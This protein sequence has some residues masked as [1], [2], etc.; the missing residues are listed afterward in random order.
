MFFLTTRTG[1]E[2]TEN[3]KKAKGTGASSS[4]NGRWVGSNWVQKWEAEKRALGEY[5]PGER[6]IVLKKK[7]HGREVALP[8]SRDRHKRRGLGVKRV[9]IAQRTGTCSMLFAL[10]P[11][12]KKKGARTD[13]WCR[14]ICSK[15]AERETDRKG[16]LVYDKTLVP[17]GPISLQ[18]NADIH[19]GNRTREQKRMFVEIDTNESTLTWRSTVQGGGTGGIACNLSE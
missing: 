5:S 3:P 12:I 14:L 6:T 9:G 13:I 11:L 1:W 17:K 8:S 4:R 7:R 19:I 16:G 18:G 2:K 10:T 15:K